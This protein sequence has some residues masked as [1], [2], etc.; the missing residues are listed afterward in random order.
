MRP[1]I[2]NLMW[3]TGAM[4]CAGASSVAA[5]EPVSTERISTE[6]LTVEQLIGNAIRAGKA[7]DVTSV[8]ALTESLSHDSVLVRQS[9]AWGLS[10]LGESASAAILS[11]THALG[12]SDSRVRWGA[13]AAIGR[14]GRKGANSESALWQM[15]RDRDLEVRCAALIALRTVSVSKPSG[16]LS[17]LIDC[18]RNPATDVQAEGIAT[19]AVIHSRWGDEE[20]RP[21]ATQLADVLENST[22]DVRLAAVVLLGDLGLAASAAISPL[23]D[24]TDDADQHVQAAALRA[25]GRFAD[26]VPGGYGGALS[27]CSDRF[28]A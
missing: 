5:S 28:I 7:R 26:E 3:L 18:L 19:F 25:V 1:T 23:A 12:D 16:A 21:I 17:A 13:A 6:R 22:D 15:T 11:L 10:Q 2:F 8:A 14:I 4:L 27:P 24:A 9:A 20:K